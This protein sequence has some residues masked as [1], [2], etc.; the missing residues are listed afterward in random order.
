[1]TGT[2]LA[3]MALSFVPIGGGEPVRMSDMK[4]RVVLMEFWKTTCGPCRIWKPAFEKLD[5]RYASK[6]L[7]VLSIDTDEAPELAVEFL[8]KHPTTLKVFADPK[9]LAQRLLAQT[10]QP[11]M[12]LFDGDGNLMWTSVGFGP[13][14]VA[15]MTWRIERYLPEEVGVGAKP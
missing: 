11:A 10:G 13:S 15:E 6:G 3:L 14:T 5:Q 2:A 1:M 8:K 12:A 7:A 9:G 4:G